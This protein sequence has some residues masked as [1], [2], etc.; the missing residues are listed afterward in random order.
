MIKLMIERGEI[1]P[2]TRLQV[3]S[4]NAHG[5]NLLLLLSIVVHFVLFQRN[6]TLLMYAVFR[7]S[8][9]IVENLLKMEG[10]NSLTDTDEVHL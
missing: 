3:G 4:C 10:F 8:K 7:G 1:S 6:R 9:V 5:I 2:R